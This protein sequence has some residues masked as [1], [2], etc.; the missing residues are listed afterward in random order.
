MDLSYQEA[1]AMTHT[2]ARRRLVETYTRTHSIAAT[3]RQ[4][5][6]SRTV[7]RKWVRRYEQQGLA[8]LDDVTRRPHHSP[9]RTP[10]EIEQAVEDARKASGYGRKRLAWLLY[11]TESLCLSPDTIRHVLRRLGYAGRAQPRQYLYPAH[12]AWEAKRPFSLVQV[13]TKDVLDRDTL[14]DK[15]WSHIIRQR[16]PRYQWTCLEARTRLRFLAYSRELSVTNGIAFMVLV[17]LHLRAHGIRGRVVWQT[18]W[19]SEFGGSSPAR[20][21]ELQRKYYGPMGAV[22]ARYPKGRKGYNG[23]VERSHRTD[24]EEFYMPCLLDITDEAGL[25]RQATAWLYYYNLVRPHQGAGMRGLAPFT[26]LQWRRKHKVPRRLALLPPVLLDTVSTDI[27]V[28][29]GNDVLT[30]YTPAGPVSADDGSGGQVRQGWLFLVQGN[31]E[32]ELGPFT[33]KRV[34]GYLAAVLDHN[35][36]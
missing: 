14:G 27:V 16:L 13:D 5:Q 35:L 36:A 20:I 7:V 3:A 34:R 22:L 12:W 33:G 29:T 30:L 1:Y 21:A 15:R 26:R 24:D 4:W 2:E 10:P 18:D 8:G 32:P 28:K 17:M 23:R 19:G 6:T 31:P 25:L 9:N 11:T